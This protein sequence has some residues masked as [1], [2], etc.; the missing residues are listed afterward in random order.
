MLDDR[1]VLPGVRFATDAYINFA[2]QQP[3]PLAVASS[4]T[5]LFAPDLMRDRIAAFEKHYSWVR[6][7]GLE[8][9][10]S[11]LTLARNDSKEALDLT[12]THCATRQ[13]QEAAVR[14]LSFKCDLLWSMLDAMLMAYGEPAGGRAT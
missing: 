8:Y 6:P 9:F 14:A 12:F 13:L 5:E 10:R 1:H 7:E 11:R 4:L 2:R 3:W